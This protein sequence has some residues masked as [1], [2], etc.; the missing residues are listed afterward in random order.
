[1][2]FLKILNSVQNNIESKCVITVKDFTTNLSSQ[3]VRSWLSS[4]IFSSFTIPLGFCS[5]EGYTV[6]LPGPVN[7]VIHPSFHGQEVYSFLPT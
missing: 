2:F 4:V 7:H 3:G 5:N 1:M 6:K